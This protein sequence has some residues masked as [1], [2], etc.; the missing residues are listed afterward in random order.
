MSRYLTIHG[1][2]AACADAFS[3]L[4][5]TRRAAIEVK[6]IDEGKQVYCEF[7]LQ[8]TRHRTKTFEGVWK[9]SVSMCVTPA[10]P[11][12]LPWLG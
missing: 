3:G 9:K 4:G 10:L 2:A 1:R 7:E 6:G 5:L 11:S 8:G 12:L